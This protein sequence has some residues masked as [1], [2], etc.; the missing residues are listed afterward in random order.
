MKYAKLNLGCGAD[1]R[2]NYLNI[3]FEKFPGVNKVYDLNK[4]PYP[5][6]KNKFDEVIMQNVLEHLNEP[7]AIMNE[8]HR[9]CRRNAKVCIKTPH[10]SSNN[11]WGDLQHKRGFNSET[12]RNQNMCKKFEILD[13]KIT[14]PHA[15]FFIRLLAK[16]NP[17]FYEKHLAYIFPACDLIIELKVL[18]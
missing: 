11:A 9:I 16:I 13:Q 18:K 1:I 6:K 2:K 15:R 7:Y 12:F 8:V 4:I 10:F 17:V 14:F 5:F 3:D